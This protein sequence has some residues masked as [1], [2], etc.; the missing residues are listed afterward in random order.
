MPGCHGE[1]RIAGEIGCFEVAKRIHIHHVSTN[2]VKPLR[3]HLAHQFRDRTFLAIRI[4][5][6]FVSVDKITDLPRQ[7]L[8]ITACCQ[9][10]P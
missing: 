7:K 4:N 1:R 9:A 10:T 2:C 3:F 8:A 5:Q 6:E